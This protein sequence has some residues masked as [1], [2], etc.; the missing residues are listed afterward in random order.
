[1]DRVKVAGINSVLIT[2]RQRRLFLVSHTLRAHVTTRLCDPHCTDDALLHHGRRSMISLRNHV[3]SNLS[4]LDL[5][6]RDVA[7][8]DTKRFHNLVAAF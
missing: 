8:F 5:E 2:I 1:M 3:S 7:Q 4:I 6:I